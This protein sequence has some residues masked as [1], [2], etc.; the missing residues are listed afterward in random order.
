[1]VMT[2][3]GDE[4]FSSGPVIAQLWFGIL[5]GPLIAAAQQEA[6]F[7]SVPV[8]HDSHRSYCYAHCGFRRVP[9]V[10]ACRRIVAHG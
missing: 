1:M 5:A 7:I 3:N 8:A 2:A 4:Y 6:A 9:A 10:E